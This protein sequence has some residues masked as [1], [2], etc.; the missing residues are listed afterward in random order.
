[1][2]FRNLI[3]VVCLVAVSATVGYEFGQQRLKWSFKNWKP[4]VVVNKLPT[5]AGKPSDV[6]FGLFWTVWD[7]MNSE[8]V[9]KTALDATKMVNGA[10]SGMVAAVGDPYTVFLPPVENKEAK[11]DLGGSFEGVGIQLGF[12]DGHLAVVSPLEG[13]PAIKAGVRAGDYILHIKDTVK[14]VDRDTEGMSLPEAVKL[15]RGPKGSKVEL[16]LLHNNNGEKPYTVELTRETIVVKSVQLEIL[17]D[18]VVWLKLNRFGDRTQDEWNEVV[19]K[20][21]GSGSKIQGVV[22]D[23]R[24]NPGG[25]LEGAV[26]V[27]GEFLP[28]G[29]NVVSQQYGDGTKVD[30]AVKRNGRLLKKPLVVLVNKGSASA[31][32]ILAGALQ[33]YKRAKI[34]GE[35]SFGKGSVQQPEDFPG[36]AGLH[37]TIAR[38]LRPNGEWID[39]KGITPDVIVKYEPDENASDSADW[40]S[41]EQLLKAVEML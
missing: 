7:K 26:Y 22:L 41:D 10:I 15:I 11:E 33:D 31:S 34:V 16:E 5:M 30:D 25:Y 8:Y 6:D 28:A 29:K 18:E 9:D 23:L 3:L 35:Q 40:K 17:D 1:M 32:E 19:S 27:A 21:Q 37:V 24:N 14:D 12:R 4:A 20:I 36:G 13:M 39:K 2:K 38:W